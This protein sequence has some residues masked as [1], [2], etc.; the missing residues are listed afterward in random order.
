MR[1]APYG[2][3]AL[4]FNLTVNV[5]ASILV[6]LLVYVLIVLAALAIHQFVTSSIIL[7]FFC[8]RNPL[9]CFSKTSA[10]MIIEFSTSSGNATLQNDMSVS[11]VKRASRRERVGRYG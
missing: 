11:K 4:L 10:V 1:L 2:V 7:K 6:D 9:K 5:G 8:G 3:A